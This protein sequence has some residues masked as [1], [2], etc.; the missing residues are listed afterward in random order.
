LASGLRLRIVALCLSGSL[1]AICGVAAGGSKSALTLHFAT[2]ERGT[3]D[4][5][6]LSAKDAS[7]ETVLSL[8]GMLLGSLIVPYLTTQ[9]STYTVLFLLLTGHLATNYAGI[10]GVVLRSLNRQRAGIA[11]TVYRT[12]AFASPDYRQ[13]GLTP[14]TLT[15][16]EV[17][18]RERVFEW[19]GILRNG[20]THRIMGHCT[21]G[22][23]FSTVLADPADHQNLL[24]IFLKERY[25]LC[26]DAS[27]IPRNRRRSRT[28]R[29][30]ICLKEG[31]TPLDQLK[32]WVH[33][34][35]V[36]RVWTAGSANNAND[37]VVVIESTYGTVDDHFAA[38]VEHMRDSG[39]NLG[40]G[41]LMTGSPKAI[42][43][44]VVD[45]T[46]EHERKKDI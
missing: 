26:F 44:S 9:W 25:I 19:P 40:E 12:D 6:E 14:K 18:S 41:A 22:S 17:A 15:P 46:F 10:R 20:C 1:R 45:G 39:W 33:A 28:L 34:E 31:Y 43:V 23:S 30:H 38:F 5:G 29:I 21:V 16:N 32:A 24:R 27:S 3:G 2:P 13:I 11:W 37:P 35:E 8:F 7:K 4:L 42:F 36:G